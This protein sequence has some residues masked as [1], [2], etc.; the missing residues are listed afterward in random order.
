[1]AQLFSL[2]GI[3]RES[4]NLNIMGRHTTDKLLA[5]AESLE[6]KIDSP[7]R[8]D[9]PRWLKQRAAKLRRW[10]A[11][12]SKGHEHKLRQKDAA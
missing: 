6:A 7:S 4:Q 1:V 8:T 10:A 12:R 5:R 11:S 3:A 2:G 9:H